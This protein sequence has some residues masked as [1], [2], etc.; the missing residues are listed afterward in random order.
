MDKHRWRVQMEGLRW[1]GYKRGRGELKKEINEK[2]K[3]K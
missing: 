2:V 1:S 3:L